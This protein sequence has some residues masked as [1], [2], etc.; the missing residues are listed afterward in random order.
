MAVIGDRIEHEIH[1]SAPPEAVFAYFTDPNEHVRWMGLQA[2]LDP[3]PGGTYR[4]EYEHAVAS[5]NS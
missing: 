4:V 5:A 2:T 3:T 1:I